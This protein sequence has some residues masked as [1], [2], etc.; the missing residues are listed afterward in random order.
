MLTGTYTPGTSFLHRARPGVKLSALAVVL[1]AVTLSRSGVVLAVFA[2]SVVGLYLAA[3]LGLRALRDELWPLRWFVVFLVPYQWWSLG[4]RGMLLA[5]GT[6][7]A[8]VAAAG[9]V[10]RTTRIADMLATLERAAAPMRLVGVDPERVAMTLSLAIRA[11]P[12][13][14]GLAQETSQARRARGLDRSVQALVTPTVVR[15]VRH[16]DRV[17]EALAARG[18]DD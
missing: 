11:I 15:A 18:F 16:A 4:W 13:V 9:L 7:L 1:L 5:T 6:L 8:S 3:G 17:G 10:T 14:V 2:A 12:V